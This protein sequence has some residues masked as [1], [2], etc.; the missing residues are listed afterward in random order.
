MMVVK[1]IFFELCGFFENIT[2]DIYIS[3]VEKK[4]DEFM[5][6]RIILKWEI[7]KVLFV[8]FLGSYLYIF[9]KYERYMRRFIYL[10]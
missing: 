6:F 7:K 4:N 2:L 5:L 3:F 10:Y 9:K 1:E 8:G